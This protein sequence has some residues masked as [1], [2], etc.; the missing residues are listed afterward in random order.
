MRKMDQIDKIMELKECFKEL[1]DLDPD[2][3]YSDLNEAKTK[4]AEKILAMVEKIS[5]DEGW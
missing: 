3:T 1:E 4:L 2:L 5:V